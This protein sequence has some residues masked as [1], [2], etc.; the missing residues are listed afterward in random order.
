MKVACPRLPT[1]IQNPVKEV[2]NCRKQRLDDISS[3]KSLD[4]VLAKQT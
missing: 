1:G 3:G 4:T 2:K